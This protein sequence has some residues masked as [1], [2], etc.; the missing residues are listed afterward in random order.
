MEEQRYFFVDQRAKEL[1]ELIAAETE[2]LRAVRSVAELLDRA[3]GGASRP[4]DDL[5]G[6]AAAQ[7]LAACRT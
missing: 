7:Y 6:P 1:E 3:H 2:S 5:A 4:A